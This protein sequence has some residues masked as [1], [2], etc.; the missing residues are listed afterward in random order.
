[1][2]NVETNYANT[3]FDLRSLKAFEALNSELSAVCCVL[4]YAE[5]Q[6]GTWWASCEADRLNDSAPNDI[7]SFIEV[8]DGLSD[9]AKKQLAD[10]TTRDFNVGI[11]CWDTCAYNLS[12]PSKIIEAVSNAGCSI[13]ITLYPMREPDGTP[14]IDEDVG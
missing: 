9:T 4:H 11:H 5:T 10:C 6:D 13:S 14:K 3:D 8:I 12:L 2:R 7:L 1:M